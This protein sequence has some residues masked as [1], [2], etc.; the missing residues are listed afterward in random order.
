LGILFLINCGIFAG[1]ALVEERLLASDPDYVRYALY[2]DERGVFSF[3]GKVFPFMR[4]SWRKKYWENK[5]VITH[6][7]DRHDNILY[8]TKTSQSL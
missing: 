1:R 3:V 8:N 4:F 7:I 5:G 2:M 6:T